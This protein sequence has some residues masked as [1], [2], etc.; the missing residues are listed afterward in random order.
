MSGLGLRPLSVLGLGM[1]RMYNT[2]ITMS[3][4]AIP[5]TGMRGDLEDA[6]SS[7]AAVVVGTSGE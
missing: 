1:F 6:V 3:M 2:I 7:R 4:N 5:G